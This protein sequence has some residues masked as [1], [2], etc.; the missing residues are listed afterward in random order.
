MTRGSRRHRAASSR[1]RQVFCRVLRSLAGVRKPDFM[2]GS[3]DSEK[4]LEEEGGGGVLVGAGAG[5]RGLGGGG[6]GLGDLCIVLVFWYFIA[7][8]F[9]FYV[10]KSIMI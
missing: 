4:N 7:V 2:L 3:S 9:M 10:R 1:K 5:G 8:L 6:C